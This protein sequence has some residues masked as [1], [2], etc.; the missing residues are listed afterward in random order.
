MA[1]RVTYA[2]RLASCMQ[3]WIARRMPTQARAVAQIVLVAVAQALRASPFALL[4][5]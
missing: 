4:K 1:W 3:R 2:M 5:R